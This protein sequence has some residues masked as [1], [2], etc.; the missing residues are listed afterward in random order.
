MN[1]FTVIMISS[2]VLVA[3]VY[4]S[5]LLPALS[6]APWVP[7]PRRRVRRLLELAGVQPGEQVLDLGSGDGRV[8]IA[9]VREFGARAVGVEIDPFRVAWSRLL[10]GVSGLRSRA[11]VEW[12]S[13][14]DAD[15]SQAD[16]VVTYLLQRTN[17]LLVKKLLHDMKPGSRLATYRFTFPLLPC[18]AHDPAAEIS[19]YRIPTS[20]P[21]S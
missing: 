6:A 21:E 10:I 3:L 13:L 12:G 1:L 11:R 17:N 2:G 14:Y 19:V 5:A 16:V 18:I 15:V 8:L 9:A 7:T 20:A 4:A